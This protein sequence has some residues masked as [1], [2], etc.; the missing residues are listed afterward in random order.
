[1]VKHLCSSSID[2]KVA[3]QFIRS[4]SGEKMKVLMILD[5]PK[6]CSLAIQLYAASDKLPSGGSRI[7]VYVISQNGRV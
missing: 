1:V 5:F 4:Y 3:G 7:F 2:K 6:S